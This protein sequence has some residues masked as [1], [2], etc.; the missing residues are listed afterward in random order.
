V[1]IDERLEKL[2]ERHEALTQSVEM[3]DAMI[4]RIDSRLDRA[5]ALAVR[6]A[7]H[8]RGRRRELGERLSQLA[9][10]QKVTEEKFQMLMD[11][12]RRGGNG[13]AKG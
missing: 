9:A 4:A 7:R 5:V 3:H 8:E 10:A 1:T 12:L 13:K 2:V 11:S 6:E